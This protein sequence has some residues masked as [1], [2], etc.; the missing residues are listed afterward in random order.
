MNLL[1]DAAL[2]KDNEYILLSWLLKEAS[3]GI[4]IIKRIGN[5]RSVILAVNDVFCQLTGL[6]HTEL[7]GQSA[8]ALLSLLREEDFC[9]FFANCA[10][11]S[12]IPLCLVIERILSTN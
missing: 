8:S 9:F 3:L 7:I 11:K 4:Y 12:L 5:N 1:P 2:S 10:S 6:K